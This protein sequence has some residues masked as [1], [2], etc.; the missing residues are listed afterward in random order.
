MLNR[1]VAAHHLMEEITVIFLEASDIFFFVR[2]YFFCQFPRIK[3]F[4]L[5]APVSARV[6]RLKD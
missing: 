2:S 6:M 3:M 5:L 4:F 1:W